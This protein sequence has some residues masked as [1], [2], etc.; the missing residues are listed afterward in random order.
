MNDPFRNYDQWLTTD[1]MA[2]AADRDAERLEDLWT[3]AVDAYN[4]PIDASEEDH[5]DHEIYVKW[6]AFIE[7]VDERERR[8]EA[9]AE[10]SFYEQMEQAEAEY[11][12]AMDAHGRGEH[13]TIPQPGTC[14][15][16]AEIEYER[17]VID[18]GY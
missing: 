17:E 13:A 4:L 11:Q 12:A 8:L 1:R 10:A 18:G 7:A 2:E 15:I 9:E 14:Q 3:L 6:L 16:C 5:D